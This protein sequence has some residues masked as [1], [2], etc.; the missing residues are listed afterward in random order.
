M[1]I[2]RKFE[3]ENDFFKQGKVNMIYGPRRAGKTALIEKILKDKADKLFI[4]SG[5]DQILRTSLN[6]ENRDYLISLFHS[7]DI[8]FIDEAQKISGI[9]SSLKILIDNMPEKT[10]IASGSSSFKLSGQVGEPLTGRNKT[11]LLYPISI[12]EWSNNFGGIDVIQ[13]LESFLI[14]GMYPEI[15]NLIGRDEKIEYLNELRNSY[16]LKDILEIENLKYTNKLFDLLRLLSYQIGNDVSL[17]ELSRNLE[18]AKQTVEKYLNLLEQAFVIVK[19]PG[20]SKNLRKEIN[21]TNRY[22]FVDNGIRNSVINNYN[23]IGFR[24]DIGRLWENFIISERIKFQNNNHIYSNNFFWRTYD[25]KEIDLVEERDGKLY[26]FEF[27]WKAQKNTSSK[28]WLKTYPNAE[29]EIINRENFITWL[30]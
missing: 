26:G 13:K 1:W 25:K 23:E 7:Y 28:T 9:G 4:G 6:S 14:F 18:I 22:Y 12:D 8:I 21:K 29:F 19:L 27:K 11:R 30:T 3:T 10:I 5:D 20:F 2:Q 16:I 17:S 24:D 15:L